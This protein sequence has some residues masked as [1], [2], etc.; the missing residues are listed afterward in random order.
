MKLTLHQITEGED[1]IVICYRS[2]NKVSVVER[3]RRAE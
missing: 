2:M 3:M 1:E